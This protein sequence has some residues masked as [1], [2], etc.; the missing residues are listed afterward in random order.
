MYACV[1]NYSKGD[2]TVYQPIG[3]EQLYMYTTQ[4]ATEVIPG[5]EANP[6]NATRKVY[7]GGSAKD[8]RFHFVNSTTVV[9]V[10]TQ[11]QLADKVHLGDVVVKVNQRS[12]P[13]SH[14]KPCKAGPMNPGP[15]AHS[16]TLKDGFVSLHLKRDSD[17]FRFF[18]HQHFLH[19]SPTAAGN[20]GEYWG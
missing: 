1:H 18:V 6:M 17:L 20:Y 7:I 5:C 12:S 2:P 13:K 4:N 14:L 16:Y 10:Q 11:G 9:V 3:N 8:F 19:Y 15:F